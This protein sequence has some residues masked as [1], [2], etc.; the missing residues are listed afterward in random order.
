VELGTFM[1][2]MAIDGICY[3]EKVK[4]RIPGDDKRCFPDGFEN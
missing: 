1:L 2:L 3:S 4:V